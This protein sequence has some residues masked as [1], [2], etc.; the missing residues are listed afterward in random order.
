MLS[1]KKRQEIKQRLQSDT[2]MIVQEMITGFS[3]EMPIEKLYRLAALNYFRKLLG[4]HNAYSVMVKA[5]PGRRAFRLM[6][7]MHSTELAQ[8]EKGLQNQEKMTRKARK[9]ISKHRQSL[10]E[11]LED[12]QQLLFEKDAMIGALRELDNEEAQMPA[13]L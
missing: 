8:V 11:M 2:G 9:K 10:M 1:K 6:S 5:E 4:N 12:D 13:Q 3:L 7:A